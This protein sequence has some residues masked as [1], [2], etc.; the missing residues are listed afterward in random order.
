MDI[1]KVAQQTGISPSALRYYEKVGLIKSNGR[2][3]L[4][5]TFSA[6]VIKKLQ[7]IRLLK[8]NHF[9]LDEIKH[10]TQTN[11][12]DRC[13]L[14]NKVEEIEKKIE[15]LAKVSDTLQHMAKCPKKDHFECES[16]Q[17]LLDN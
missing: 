2:N 14:L 1:G 10:L 5:R 9:S 13:F 6:S 11:L 16:F 7:L 8:R 4:R 3:G 12:L 17:K 15:E